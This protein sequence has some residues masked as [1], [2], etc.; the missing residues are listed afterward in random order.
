MRLT[1]EL[2]DADMANIGGIY[3]WTQADYN[4]LVA[5]L[6]AMQA[7]TTSIQSAI[8]KLLT[9]EQKQ[10]SAID[11]LKA[12][13][14]QTQSVEQSAVVLIQGIAKQ[15]NDALTNNSAAANDPALAQLRDQLNSSSAELGAAVAAN[16]G[17]GPAPAPA[18]DPNA[19]QVNPLSG[20]R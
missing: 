3:L 5:Q 10:M 12:A 16:T 11:D 14:E 9:Q 18:P 15:L 17:Q 1:I 2:E 4:K 7:A 13:V 6:G 20:R 19:P 8:N